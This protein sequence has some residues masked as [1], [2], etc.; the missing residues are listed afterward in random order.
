LRVVFGDGRLPGSDD[1]PSVWGH[2]PLLV[3]DSTW[4]ITVEPMTDT[5]MASTLEGYGFDTSVLFQG[6]LLQDGTDWLDGMGPLW[7]GSLYADAT[8]LDTARTVLAADM[9]T[10][11][12]VFFGSGWYLWSFDL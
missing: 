2:D 6:L 7:W 9:E 4:E 12:F 10:T 1:R 11:D 8:P 5:T 3:A